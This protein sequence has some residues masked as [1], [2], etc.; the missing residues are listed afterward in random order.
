METSIFLAKVTSLY[1][2]ILGLGL[3]VRKDHF[4]EMFKAFFGRKSALFLGGLFVLIIGILMV[5]AHPQFTADWRSW[6]TAI[7][8]LAMFIILPNF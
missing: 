2:V 7:G 3:L 8:Y 6:I 1:F 5:A 4:K